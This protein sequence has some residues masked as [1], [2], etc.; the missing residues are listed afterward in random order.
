M[1][2]LR[3]GIAVLLLY[4]VVLWSQV[5][6][7][8]SLENL[9]SHT[10][11]T[12][13]RYEL[14]NKLAPL[15]I[16]FETPEKS[17]VYLNELKKLAHQKKD[18]KNEAKTYRAFSMIYL[19]KADYTAAIDQ[20][21]KAIEIDKKHNCLKCYLLD[22]NQLG[23]IYIDLQK[24]RKALEI[25][26]EA[27]RKTGNQ[28][29]T[30]ILSVLAIIYGNIG[31]AY[32]KI[33]Q[34]EKEINA[35][36]KQAEL[37]EKAGNYNEKSK[38]FYNIGYLYMEMEQYPIAEKYFFK[39]MSD[40][41]KISNKDYVKI[42]YHSLGIL[43]SRWKKFDQA[44]HYDSLAL[45]YFKKNGYSLYVFDV[46]N[47]MA[48][49][50]QRMNR[51]DKALPYH[52]KAVKLADSLKHKLIQIGGKLSFVKS[53]IHLKKYQKAEKILKQ[54]AKD[55]VDHQN[56]NKSLLAD[57]W[58]YNFLI[59]KHQKKYKK[60]LEFFEKYHNLNDSLSNKERDIK[61]AELE[62][63]YQT[64]AKEKE[65]AQK[66]K[67]LLK[68]KIVRQRLL[69]GLS[70]LVVLLIL[71]SIVTARI[72]KKHLI[73]KRKLNEL[74]QKVKELTRQL[75]TNEPKII[76]QKS[77]LNP[78]YFNNNAEFRTDKSTYFQEKSEKLKEFHHY[79]QETFNINKPILI[80][81]WESIANG[82]SRKEFADRFD[83][84]ENTVKA[85]R[86]E[87]YQTLKAYEGT[88]ERYTDYKAT[89]LYYQM[90]LE[91]LFKNKF[92]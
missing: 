19:N 22:I 5:Q 51:Y 67:E 81:V 53:L 64:E 78:A 7:K 46:L 52:L 73:E 74:V 2:F 31:I 85:W 59:Y 6:K 16:N 80:E 79:L 68:Q 25:Y 58:K 90:L 83:Y 61:I 60:A 23:R 21:E 86:K 82:V 63:K 50:Y 15:L 29:N 20:I 89:G 65:L 17:A 10:T 76:E 37:S 44:L 71:I 13:K 40:S 55:T 38:A 45:D 69:F 18:Y 77:G 12:E 49:V 27:I 30:D 54:I 70:S 41:L 36:L 47:N 28:S 62:T 87:L 42:N 39:A 32:G 4:P 8:D 92:I 34:N 26:Q 57:F 24:P 48:V 66:E 43:Y 72:Y 3:I 56:F 33:N 88:S 14:L 75:E 9:L 84:S 91:F 1:N 11:G 35:F